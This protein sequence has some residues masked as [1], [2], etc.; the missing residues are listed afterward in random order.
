MLSANPK[1]TE[2]WHQ[3]PSLSQVPP[4]LTILSSSR[5]TFWLL[6]YEG[7]PQKQV[8]DRCDRFFGDLYL[9]EPKYHLTQTKLIEYKELSKEIEALEKRVNE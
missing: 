2:I 8:N 3:D 9:E 6:R 5:R 1:L 7:P 4:K